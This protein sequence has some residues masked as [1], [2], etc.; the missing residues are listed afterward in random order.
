M[1]SVSSR[2]MGNLM[3]TLPC[4]VLTPRPARSY[5]GMRLSLG[6]RCQA[7]WMDG[8]YYDATVQKYHADGTVVVNWLRPRPDGGETSPNARPLVTISEHGGDDSLHRIV[9]RTDIRADTSADPEMRSDQQVALDFFAGRPQE[10][11]LC[12][13]CGAAAVDWASVSFGTYL[14]RECA[15]E[16]QA[17]GVRYSL[18]RQLNDGWGWAQRDLE[19]L[20]RGGNAAFTACLERYPTVKLKTLP[21]LY[22]SRFAEY[23]RKQLDS[24]VTGAQIPLP[25]SPEQAEKPGEKGEFLSAAEAS[26]VAQEVA[27]R[28]EAT[29]QHA[30]RQSPGSHPLAHAQCWQP[31]ASRYGPPGSSVS[32]SVERSMAATPAS[33][34]PHLAHSG[35]I[36]KVIVC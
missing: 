1:R 21:E 26:A 28:F 20:R 3:S 17:L 2:I 6:M 10:D 5:G 8:H 4:S 13:D 14:C 34:G 33:M 27:R 22:S 24:L 18:V 7:K 29:V 30:I 9:S 23:Y 12:A 36:Q 25:P 15:D 16:H 32:L 19:Y 31:G 35:K 11:N